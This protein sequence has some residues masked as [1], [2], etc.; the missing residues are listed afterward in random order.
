MVTRPE[1]RKLVATTTRRRKGEINAT[2][3]SK[4]SPNAKWKHSG[5]LSGNWSHRRDK[6]ETE[7]LLKAE[8]RNIFSSPFLLISSLSLMP[9]IGQTLQMPECKG[10]WKVEL[11]PICRRAGNASESK[12]EK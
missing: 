12:T 4:P 9:P 2:E 1:V 7:P 3:V 10:T 11:P 5:Q 6:G 8:K